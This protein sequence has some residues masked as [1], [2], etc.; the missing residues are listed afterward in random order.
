M[1]DL[2][3][4]MV[5]DQ[6][7]A[8]TA[9]QTPPVT[10]EPLYTKLAPV[11]QQTILDRCTQSTYLTDDQDRVLLDEAGEPIRE[12][13]VVYEDLYDVGHMLL[14]HLSRTTYY[15][16]QEA[17]SAYWS[18][19]GRIYKRLWAKYRARR[20]N[21]A[22]NILTNILELKKEIIMGDAKEGR[23]QT[24]DVKMAGSYRQVDIGRGREQGSSF[25]DRLRGGG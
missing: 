8:Q 24:Y 23:R 22:L 6:I 14:T 5:S 11:I 16:E 12:Q 18:F 20:D 10:G 17:R 25:L 2:E 21:R 7:L 19:Y 1:S 15:T 13:V 3:R 9:S 4:D